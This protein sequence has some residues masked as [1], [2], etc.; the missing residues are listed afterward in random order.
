MLLVACT[1]LRA[2]EAV[3]LRWGDIKDGL[4]HVRRRWSAATLDEP[5]TARSKAPVA[6]HPM[7]LHFLRE[8]RKMSPYVSDGDWIFPSIKMHGT[9]PMSAGIFV[10]DYLRP[11]ALKIGIT[12]PDDQRFGL[13]S[14]R[15]SLA[16]WMVSVAKTDLKTAQGSLRHANPQVL[17]DRYARAVTDEMVAAQG[18][19][20]EACGM[21]VE[22]KILPQS[23]TD[24]IRSVGA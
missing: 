17:L 3:G 10:T 21:A 15:S 7:L 13:H 11:A 18:R 14:F 20:L 1:G 12:I 22:R 5:K 24:R 16:T 8:W 6:C 9:I 19:F 23:A 4:I 2:S